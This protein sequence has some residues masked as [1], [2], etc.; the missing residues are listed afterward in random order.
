M[1][2][3]DTSLASIDALQK[4]HSI[5]SSARSWIAVDRSMPQRSNHGG[6][7]VPTGALPGLPHCR[8]R[9]SAGTRWRRGA[10]VIDGQLR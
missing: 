6:L 8:R 7:L 9:R 5:T 10:A 3:S 1:T 2:H 4:V